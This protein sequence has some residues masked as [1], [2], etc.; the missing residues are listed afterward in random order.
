LPGQVTVAR[1]NGNRKKIVPAFPDVIIE[2]PVWSWERADG[3]VENGQQP[4]PIKK[5]REW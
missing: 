5:T 1:D 3:D 2:E 4:V